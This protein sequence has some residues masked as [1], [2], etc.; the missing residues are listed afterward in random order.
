MLS[1]TI[2][3]ASFVLDQTSTGPSNIQGENPSYSNLKSSAE[4]TWK[5]GAWRKG[6][7]TGAEESAMIPLVDFRMMGRF[8]ASKQLQ[9]HAGVQ[10]SLGCKS[11]KRNVKWSLMLMCVRHTHLSASVFEEMNKEPGE[12]TKNE[13]RLLI[14]LF[15]FM[16]CLFQR[17]IQKLC[18]SSHS[19]N[20]QM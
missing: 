14:M 11:Q 9:K 4:A 12:F 3:H 10:R 13:L 18:K 19:E 5:N 1:D 20:A 15:I 6:V 16:S 2:F 17:A 8:Y 7:A